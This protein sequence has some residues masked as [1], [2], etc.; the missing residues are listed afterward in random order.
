MPSITQLRDQ[1]NLARDTELAKGRWVSLSSPL[2]DY[3]LYSALIPRMISK[4]SHTIAFTISQDEVGKTTDLT[5]FFVGV[6]TPI[7]PASHAA[8]KRPSVNLA[9]ARE[10]TTYA[11]DEPELQGTSEEELADIVVMRKAEQLDLPLLAKQELS[12]TREPA[13]STAEQEVFGLPYWFPHDSTATDIE[14][15]GGG[16]PSNHSGGAAGITVAEAPRWA[17]AVGGFDKISDDDLFDKLQEFH[18]RVNAYVPEGVPAL[19]SGMPERCILCQSPVFVQWARLQQV[20]NDNPGRDLGMWRD[21]IWYSGTPVKWWPAFSEPDS[22]GTPTGY[23]LIYDLD[24]T[25]LKLAFHSGFQFDL[26]VREPQDQPR[27]IWLVREGY[28]QL[29][30]VRRN[31]NLVMYTDNTALISKAS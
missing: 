11:E 23:G 15:Y 19:D 24:L 26:E 12:L 10:T 3:P 13:S 17:H 4:W 29:I 5:N 31:R 6:G 25:T 28:Y 7:S 16:N 20:A 27:V 8:T 30:C 14:L 21:A 2:P 1:L 9:K 18:I 22:S